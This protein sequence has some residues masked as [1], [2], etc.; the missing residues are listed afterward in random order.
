MPYTKEQIIEEAVNI[1]GDKYDYSKVEDVRNVNT[2]FTVICP[3]HGEFQTTY[4]NHVRY[5]KGCNKC[6]YAQKAKNRIIKKESFIERASK[7]HSD[8]DNYD[9]TVLDMH[10]RDEYGRVNIY[11]KKHG[12]FRIRPQ[13]F[14]DGVGCQRCNGSQKSD[15]EVVD[16]LSR[17]HPN[18][19]FSITKY[20]ERDENYRI[21]VIC[22]IHGT[23]H[24]N[25]YNLRNG[26][27]CDLCDESHIEREIE[28]VLK[29]NGLKY[30]RE[31]KFTWLKYK[32]GLRL[33][34]YLPDYNI[35]IECQG[36]Q[37]FAPYD[38]FGGEEGFEDDLK[39]DETKKILCEKHNVKLF[40][41]S[42]VKNVK[43]PY[44]VY[45]DTNELLE[46]IKKG[47]QL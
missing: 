20:S 7:N 11:C 40:Y 8:M 9:F 10:N 39:R 33:D 24:L 26:Q 36:V 19:D 38:Y 28:T 23:R 32:R 2:K 37:H 1:H 35:A 5:H 45:T 41:Y 16:E 14:I 12:W 42:N 4:W 15:E 21:D 13:H 27:G 31:K 18:L 6:A 30:E 46:D 44:D 29:E 22:P 3:E 17:I 47:N 25:Y 43:F 34:F